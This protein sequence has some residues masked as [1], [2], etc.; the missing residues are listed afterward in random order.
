MKFKGLKP[1][2]HIPERGIYTKTARFI[3]KN[4]LESKQEK[5]EVNIDFERGEDLLSLYNAMK[6]LVRRE[7]IPLK[8]TIDQKEGKL[9]IQ[10]L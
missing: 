6:S 2:E 8:P 10:K 9:Y 3:F 7:K 4:F 1:V 5:A